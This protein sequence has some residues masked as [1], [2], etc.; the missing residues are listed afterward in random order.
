MDTTLLAEDPEEANFTMATLSETFLSTTLSETFV[1][2][3]R[4]GGS[5]DND[6]ALFAANLLEVRYLKFDLYHTFKYNVN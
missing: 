5:S 4:S 3:K 1:A 6:I 2:A